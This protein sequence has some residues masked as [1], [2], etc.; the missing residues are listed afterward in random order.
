MKAQAQLEFPLF[1]GEAMTQLPEDLFIP[2]E[3]L[4]IYLEDFSDF[5]KETLDEHFGFSRYAERLGRS[6]NSF[7]ELYARYADKLYG[8]FYKML[9]QS[10]DIR[11]QFPKI[12]GVFNN[13]NFIWPG[14]RHQAGTGWTAYR[15]LAVSPVKPPTLLRQ[16]VQVGRLGNRRSVASKLRSQ[17]IYRNK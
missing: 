13:P 7:D 1:K 8:Y 15:L 6:A 16:F 11:I 4:E 9:W 3:A 12:S 5:I 2:P 10:Y 17:I 14:T